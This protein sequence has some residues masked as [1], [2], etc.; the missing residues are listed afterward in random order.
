[1]REET[2]ALTGPLSWSWHQ[3]RKCC[4]GQRTCEVHLALHPILPT[5]I[6]DVPAKGHSNLWQSPCAS[7]RPL[8][9]AKVHPDPTPVFHNDPV[10]LPLNLTM[11]SAGFSPPQRPENGTHQNYE[12]RASR[13]TSRTGR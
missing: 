6:C 5:G 13:V 12:H 11:P 1:M 4:P 10:P 2:D 9:P 7:L 8:S 3:G